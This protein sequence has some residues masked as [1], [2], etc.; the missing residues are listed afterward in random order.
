MSVYVTPLMVN[1]PVRVP[2]RL[3]HSSRVHALGSGASFSRDEPLLLIASEGLDLVSQVQAD[4]A[5]DLDGLGE[6]A[7]TDTIGDGLG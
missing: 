2:R 4:P 1:V 7:S 5:S 6:G 3:S